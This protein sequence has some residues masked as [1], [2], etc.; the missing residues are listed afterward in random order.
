MTES[1][2]GTKLPLELWARAGQG[3]DRA[4]NTPPSIGQWTGVLKELISIFN[5]PS[6]AL[7]LWEPLA[8]CHHL[9]LGVTCLVQPQAQHGAYPCASFWNSWLDPTVVH[10]HTPSHQWLSMH[11]WWPGDP[12]S[13]SQTQL[14]EP[15]A[16]SHTKGPK[17]NPVICNNLV[18]SQ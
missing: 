4:V 9:P 15:P 3:A 1:S 6:G 17:T 7:G 18:Y 10:S 16:A 8:V 12:W 5:T 11:L 13:A 2:N 14:G